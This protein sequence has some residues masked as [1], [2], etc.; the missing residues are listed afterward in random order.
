MAQISDPG[1]L[2]TFRQWSALAVNPLTDDPPVG[3]TSPRSA[4]CRTLRTR[5]VRAP[6]RTD[7]PAPAPALRHGHS[8]SRESIAGCGLLDTR[9][10]ASDRP[11]LRGIGLDL[12]YPPVTCSRIQRIATPDPS[13][14][15]LLSTPRTCRKPAV[16]FVCAVSEDS[17]RAT[18]P[19]ASSSFTNTLKL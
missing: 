5:G 19:A 4:S 9:R 16:H 3:S 7:L 1:Q 11:R 12:S 18:H 2:P 13:R 6:E 15:S 10:R 14:S 17:S 8:E